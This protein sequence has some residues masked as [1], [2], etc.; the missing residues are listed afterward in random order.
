MDV[1]QGELPFIGIQY[2][3][4][5]STQLLVTLDPHIGCSLPNKSHEQALHPLMKWLALSQITCHLTQH[6]SLTKFHT[7]PFSGSSHS[8]YSG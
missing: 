7:E 3:I 2:Y 6:S 5:G 1:T 4:R 8:S